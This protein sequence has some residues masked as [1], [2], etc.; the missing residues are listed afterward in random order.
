MRFLDERLFR[1]F[2]LPFNELC[3]PCS[4][5]AALDLSGQTCIIAEDKMTFLTLPAIPGTL[6][7]LGGGFKVSS[8]AVISWLRSCPIVCWGDLDARGFQIL[9]QLRSVFPHI[10]SVM[11]DEPTLNAFAEFCVTGTPCCVRQL[12]HLTPEGHALFLRLV[13]DTRCLEQARI[14][15]GYALQQLRACLAGLT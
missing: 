6:A 13:E 3:A 1:R 14:S 15:Q 9:S 10:I 7:I 2:G 12:P 5:L 4:Q 11:M 8:L